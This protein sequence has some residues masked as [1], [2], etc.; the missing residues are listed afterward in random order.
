[1]SV[2]N[3]PPESEKQLKDLKFGEKTV[4]EIDGK[5]TEVVIDGNLEEI[6]YLLDKDPVIRESGI[7]EL[8]SD[9]RVARLVTAHLSENNNSDI[10]F[11]F[12]NKKVDFGDGKQW[13]L[14]QIPS[15]PIMRNMLN[16][17]LEF[18]TPPD[19]EYESI[20]STYG[21][22]I[23]LTGSNSINSLIV[24]SLLGNDGQLKNIEID[25]YGVYIN[26]KGEVIRQDIIGFYDSLEKHLKE[27]TIK[28]NIRKEARF[29]NYNILS[30]YGIDLSKIVKLN[31]NELPTLNIDGKLDESKEELMKNPD[32]AKS[33][34]FDIRDKRAIRAVEAWIDFR[35][36]STIAGKPTRVTVG[37]KPEKL[38]DL[39]SGTADFGDGVKWIVK[40]IPLTKS[41][42]NCEQE[43]FYQGWAFN[44]GVEGEPG[45]TLAVIDIFDEH[46]C[47]DSIHVILAGTYKNQDGKIVEHKASG[48]YYPSLKRVSGFEVQEKIRIKE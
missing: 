31:R 8:C 20:G 34:I 30:L 9:P 4:V 1:M 3:T 18:F 44:L 40:Q 39:R 26:E 38:V 32:I 12:N 45:L 2:S 17:Q 47:F 35:E 25:L 14:K 22:V 6:K 19:K 29:I 33:G 10:V 7:F 11:D 48:K 42:D 16:G 43:I 28:E 37:K 15:T 21:L 5:K 36:N 13:D 46:K 24:M 41:V 27:N 23:S